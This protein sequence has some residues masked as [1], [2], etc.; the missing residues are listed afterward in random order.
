MGLCG[1][2]AVERRCLA[3]KEVTESCFPRFWV[4]LCSERYWDSSLCPHRE[5][6][7][8]LAG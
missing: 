8:S 5:R 7:G 3:R 2:E 6:L 4:A 1:K